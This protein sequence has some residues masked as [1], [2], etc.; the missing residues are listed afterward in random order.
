MSRL[1]DPRLGKRRYY[2]GFD[3]THRKQFH[4]YFF[5][6]ARQQSYTRKRTD[7][8]CDSFIGLFVENF[9]RSRRYVGRNFVYAVTV[10][11]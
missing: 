8:N 9:L 5:T 6:E 7:G 2:F 1:I 4:P 10:G 3:E 11:T